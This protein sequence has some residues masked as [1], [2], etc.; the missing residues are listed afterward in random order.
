MATFAAVLVN[1]NSGPELRR[2][3]ESIEREAGASWEG[4]SST[5]TPRMAVSVR[6]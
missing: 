3:L 2:A 4:V 1:Y 5:T 6:R